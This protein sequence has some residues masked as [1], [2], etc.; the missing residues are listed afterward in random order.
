MSRSCPASTSRRTPTSIA[1]SAATRSADRNGL[2]GDPQR[3]AGDGH[4]AIQVA[5]I[6]IEPVQGEGG[7]D[8]APPA[9]LRGL[10]ALCDAHGILL[11]L[12]EVQ[13]GYGRTGRMWGFEHAGIVPDVVCIAKAIANGLPLSAIVDPSGAP[14]AL[15]PGRPRLDVRRQPRLLRR[16][17][18]GARDD[19]A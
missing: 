14:G 7:Y 10:R 1:T 11:I 8:P 13:S 16:R 15:G 6:L 17:R 19:R 4:R 3:A 9:F 5:A 2:P 12:D 18:R